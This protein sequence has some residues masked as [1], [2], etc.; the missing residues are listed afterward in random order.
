MEIELPFEEDL[1]AQFE[2]MKYLTNALIENEKDLDKNMSEKA[3]S[4]WID[5]HEY[6]RKSLSHIREIQ[7][8]YI[9]KI[10]GISN[11][12]ACNQEFKSNKL[13]MF[14]GSVYCITCHGNCFSGYNGSR[15]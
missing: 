14:C 9:Q 7:F 15:D 13:Y 2:W 5:Q 10:S 3:Y 12:S 6:C 1:N 11:C 8:Q 4:K